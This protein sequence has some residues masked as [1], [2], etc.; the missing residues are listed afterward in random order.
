[1]WVYLCDATSFKR[2]KVQ[3]VNFTIACRRTNV[4]NEDLQSYYTH[5]GMKE[6]SGRLS[7]WWSQSCWVIAQVRPIRIRWFS[8]IFLTPLVGVPYRADNYS[9]LR[10]LRHTQPLPPGLFGI[11]TFIILW[12]EICKKS[13][14]LL[15]NEDVYAGIFD[16]LKDIWRTSTHVGKTPFT[17]WF[18]AYWSALSLRIILICFLQSSLNIPFEFLL[19]VTSVEVVTLETVWQIDHIGGQKSF[20]TECN[21]VM[22]FKAECLTVRKLRLK[23]MSSL[24]CAPKYA[25]SLC[26]RENLKAFPPWAS[27]TGVD[28][29]GAFWLNSTQT[30]KSKQAAS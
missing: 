16:P 12:N 28:L 13:E 21:D 8:T 18:C 24:T 30:Q 11:I 2:S 17:T 23:F 3:R 5:H 29:R 10:S 19:I 1:M 20:L 22:I 6:A 15:T 14:I 4:E 27:I 26:C 9:P 25:S 7:P